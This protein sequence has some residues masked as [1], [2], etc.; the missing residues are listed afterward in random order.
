MN[1]REQPA[2]PRDQE[3]ARRP[4]RAV[5]IVQV[6]LAVAAMVV[7]A[8]LGAWGAAVWFLGPYLVWA[9]E[10]IHL[11][12]QTPKAVA[13]GEPFELTLSIRND[14]P[15][16]RTLEAVAIELDYLQGFSVQDLQPP[17]T[18]TAPATDHRVYRYDLAVPAGAVTPIRLT[19][20]AVEPGAFQGR[21]EVQFVGE[22]RIG[23]T[24]AATAVVA[25][26]GTPP[27][28]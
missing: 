4:R 8:S 24:H 12:V 5:R 21:V 14:G 26:E 27:A 1:P 11:S 20:R 18:S 25:R 22:S 17:P 3:A 7:L 28:P 6:L 16:D 15:T 13:V 19:L 10:G 9:P 23:R 2:T